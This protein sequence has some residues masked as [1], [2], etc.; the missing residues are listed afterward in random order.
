M[1]EKLS[2]TSWAP[3]LRPEALWRL[4]VDLD[5]MVGDDCS[6][7]GELVVAQAKPICSGTHSPED[8]LGEEDGGASRLRS[9]V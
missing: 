9:F 8:V 1:R 7:G 3:S 6:D 4:A 2:L 5:S